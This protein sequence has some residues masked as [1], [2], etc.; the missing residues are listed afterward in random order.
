MRKTL[1]KTRGFTLIELL[2]VIT[3]FVIIILLAV[4]SIKGS[5][6]RSKNARIAS[7]L[8]EVRKLAEKIFITSANG[9]TNLCSSFGNLHLNT[10]DADLEILE[11]DIVEMGGET[12]C[13]A[14]KD[15][16]CVNVKLT[17]E[18]GYLCIDGF[19]RFGPPTLTPSCTGPTSDC[20]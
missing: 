13:Y 6:V 4:I 17:G 19:G 10:S 20:P 9:Y 18:Q 16:F 2:I 14:S 15:N 11:K 3:I 12:T 1:I 7:S 8:A 5:I